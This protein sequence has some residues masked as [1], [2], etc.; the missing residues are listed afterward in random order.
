MTFTYIRLFNRLLFTR[1]THASVSNGFVPLYNQHV[2]YKDV[3][4]TNTL[5]KDLNV[6]KTNVKEQIA[7]EFRQDRQ[8]LR[9]SAHLLGNTP[10]I[11]VS[12]SQNWKRKVRQSKNVSGN[13]TDSHQWSGHLECNIHTY[14]QHEKIIKPWDS[15]AQSLFLVSL[16]NISTLKRRA[17]KIKKHKKKKRKKKW[18]RMDAIPWKP[19]SEHKI[20]YQL[21][22]KIR[23][24]VKEKRRRKKGNR[25]LRAPRQ[26]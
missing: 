16:R 7:Y 23:R 18:S 17:F 21:P 15:L 12:N 20:T 3:E 8:C 25:T 26:R 24:I 4:N 10:Y 14:F 2:V 13:F 6:A 5:Y 1:K 19:P 9:P 22:C 11:D